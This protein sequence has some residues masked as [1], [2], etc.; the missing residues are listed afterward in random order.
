MEAQRPRK[1]DEKKCQREGNACLFVVQIRKQS[2]LPIL[3]KWHPR[4]PRSHIIMREEADQNQLLRVRLTAQ[5]YKGISMMPASALHGYAQT[6]LRVK[7]RSSLQ[8]IVAIKSLSQPCTVSLASSFF[9]S[10]KKPEYHV[11]GY[12]AKKPCNSPFLSGRQAT[13]CVII[14]IQRNFLLPVVPSDG[15][16]M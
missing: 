12:R 14:Y 11:S 16:H 3:I 4:P 15:D 1:Q 9:L 2:R 8:I 13:A 10:Q 5:Y 6:D 7:P